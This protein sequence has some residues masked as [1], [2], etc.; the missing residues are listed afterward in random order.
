MNLG[1]SPSASMVNTGASRSP[2][3][4]AGAGVGIVGRFSASCASG[5]EPP[6][7]LW[8]KNPSYTR[9]SGCTALT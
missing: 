6:D 3:I 4:R 1:T 2:R 7:L 5:A 8:M 9:A